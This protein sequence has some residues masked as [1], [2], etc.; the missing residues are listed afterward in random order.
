MWRPNHLKSLTWETRTPTL[1][2]HRYHYNDNVY[3]VSNVN[4]VDLRTYNKFKYNDNAVV[5]FVGYP[6]SLK[7]KARLFELPQEAS[8]NC[9]K[10]TPKRALSDYL[11][12]ADVAN[13]KK[14]LCKSRCKQCTYTFDSP[15][16]EDTFLDIHRQNNK[17]KGYNP[18]LSLPGVYADRSKESVEKYATYNLE[19]AYNDP[20]AEDY[21]DNMI[22]KY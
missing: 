13:G 11:Y 2:Q 17:I 14:N 1:P 8:K 10:I 20:I 4:D 12:R 16:L 3:N 22:Y 7:G 9:A 5:D 19:K 6:H 18:N 15:L 21:V